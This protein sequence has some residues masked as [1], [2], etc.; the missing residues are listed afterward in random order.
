[1]SEFDR[2]ADGLAN[3]VLSEMAD[4]F[5]G[6]RREMDE[7]IEQFKKLV[8]ELKKLQDQAE[9]FAEILH[10]VLLGEEGA[11]GFYEAIGL[12]AAQLPLCMECTI[13][14]LLEGL[15][16]AFTHKGRFRKLVI[17]AYRNM[18]DNVEDYLHGHEYADRDEPRRRRV[19]VHYESLKRMEARL[20][21]QIEK[22]NRQSS[23]SN[24]LQYVRG[25]N[26]AEQEREKIAGAPAFDDPQRLDST[27][28]YPRQDMSSEG[29]KS[30]PEFPAFKDVE[31]E[32]RQF[33]DAFYARN[34]AAVRAMLRELREAQQ[35][36][37]P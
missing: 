18:R 5:F 26:P 15:P 21:L 4:N 37:N 7:Q 13:P 6:A 8:R 19:S 34:K 11:V 32:I 28:A 30:F 17:L 25:L 10:F 2:F 16:F 3:E 35:N 31:S 20:N 36:V 29:L 23:V 12:D 22:L 27:F 33:V 24:T 14:P 9:H 1:M